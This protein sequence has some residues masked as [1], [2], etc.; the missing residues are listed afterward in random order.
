VYDTG[1][2]LSGFEQKNTPATRI[3]ITH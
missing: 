3:Q 1:H 2:T